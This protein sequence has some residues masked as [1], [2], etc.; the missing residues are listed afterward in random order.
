MLGG[1]PFEQARAVA[2]LAT[3]VRAAALSVMVYTGFTLDALRSGAVD[4][5]AELLAQ[6]DLLVDGRY[7]RELPE[8]SRRWVGSS[9]QVVHFLSDRYAK[10]DPRFSSGNTVELRLTRDG[11]VVNGWPAGTGVLGPK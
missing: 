5:A 1:E 7:R 3:L 2:E 8:V 10:D 9:N 11:L 6:T 4:G